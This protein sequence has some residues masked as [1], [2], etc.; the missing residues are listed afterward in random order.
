MPLQY[1]C[2][3]VEMKPKDETSS[4]LL[5]LEIDEFVD[6]HSIPLELTLVHDDNPELVKTVS[7]WSGIALILSSI[8]GSGIFAS[9]GP[10]LTY[11][12]SVG[13]ALICW[14]LA[15]LL[16][17][18]GSFCYAELGTMMPSSGGE[19]PYLFRAFGSLPPFLFSWTGITLTRPA[20][21][22]IVSTICADYVGKLIYASQNDT[23]PQY[24]VKIIAICIISSLTLVNCL[25]T[26]LG[27]ILQN[28][29]TIFKISSLVIIGIIG[30]NALGKTKSVLTQ[31][32]VFTGSST[33][34]G[35]YALAMYSALWA[36]DG[37]YL[38]SFHF[39]E[40]NRNNL[41]LVTGELK[42]PTKNLPKATIIGPSIVIACYLLVNM[43]YY[44][45]LPLD[46]VTKSSAIAMVNSLLPRENLRLKG[47]WQSF[48][49]PC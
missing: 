18:T 42:D 10:V 6:S 48:N 21:I 8:I 1:L 7:L 13:M 41:N 33:N 46:V 27:N 39:I 45:S 36:Y 34:A 12:K 49:G 14:F 11:T 9:P 16:A 38:F 15:G 30:L 28:A 43:A 4:E 37:W 3:F 2:P 26:R 20:S 5:L 29:C 35:D 25:S 40:I 24:S 32:G 44:S 19:H 22:A 17:I 31:S 47:L 23:I